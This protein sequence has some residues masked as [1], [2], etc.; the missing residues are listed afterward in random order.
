MAHFAPCKNESTARDLASEYYR[1]VWKLHGVPLRMTTDCG[2]EF[3]NKFSAA[4]CE[5]VGTVHSR[6]TAYHPQSDG[7]T[8]RMNR[9]LD[10]M[11]R[12]YVNPQQDNWEKLLPAA[13]FA[14]N[15]AFHESIQ[16]TPFY[17]NNGRHPRLPSNLDLGLKP[18]KNPAAYDFI[19]NIEKALIRARFCLQAAQQRQKQYADDKQGDLH[20]KVGDSVYLS[21][22]HIILKAVGARKLL[23]RWLRPFNV[24]EK[25][26]T[27]NYTLD[28]AAHY[29]IHPT[30]HVSMLRPAYDNGSGEGRPPLIMIDGEE[31]F[32]L[33][34]ILQHRPLNK[35]NGDSGISY[36]V[37]WTGHGPVHNSW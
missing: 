24:L 27:V 29:R 12:H 19:G 9:V 32:E 30:F 2:S 13:E 8:Q 33:Q 36:L 37:K 5:L 4:L 17:L 18:K 25:V 34:T 16:D 28:I 3:V 10:D 20:V 21:S 1:S 7:Q 31:E 11:L 6:S 22:E 15:N 14:V 35:T 23:L 26:T